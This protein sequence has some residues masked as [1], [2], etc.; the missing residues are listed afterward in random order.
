MRGG[1]RCP[2]IRHIS[3]TTPSGVGFAAQQLP[4]QTW[5][6][7]RTQRELETRR[8]KIARAAVA[9]QHTPSGHQDMQTAFRQSN[10]PFSEHPS[11]LPDKPFPP[12]NARFLP[13]KIR[14]HRRCRFAR[15]TQLR[16]NSIGGICSAPPK[17]RVKSALKSAHYVGV[18]ISFLHKKPLL[19]PGER[20]VQPLGFGEKRVA[21]V[22]RPH[23]REENRVPLAALEPAPALRPAA[24]GGALLDRAE[25][26][27]RLSRD[28]ARPSRPRRISPV[29]TPEQ[30]R[31]SLCTRKTSSIEHP[32]LCALPTY[33]AC[34]KAALVV[35]A[36]S[37]VSAA[38]H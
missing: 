31:C 6:S 1:R 23:G 12:A 15:P 25:S 27:R 14:H 3:R 11:L 28:R 8:F 33:C 4:R 18:P 7:F 32:P 36:Q 13:T 22:G 19:R 37:A 21:S 26:A 16:P 30:E 17:R 10:R 24:A 9:R 38:T 34:C 20:H 5:V 29:A 2:V 35:S